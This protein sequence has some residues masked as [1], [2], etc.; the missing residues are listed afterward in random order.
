VQSIT[1]ECCLL[2][3]K[4]NVNCAVTDQCIVH[5]CPFKQWNV[6]AACYLQAFD[7]FDNILKNNLTQESLNVQLFLTH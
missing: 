6:K 3:T 4:V 2:G 5:E 1:V 7:S